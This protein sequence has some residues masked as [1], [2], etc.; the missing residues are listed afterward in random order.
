M[1]VLI[2]FHGGGWRQ[3]DKSDIEKPN[4]AYIRDAM[5][6]RG[7]AVISA[8][9]R[10]IGPPLT[11]SA[12]AED[13]KDVIRWVYKNAVLYD[14]DTD[15]IGLWGTSSGAHLAMLMAYSAD[16]DFLGADELQP[17]SSVANYV[18]DTFG[19]AD[20]NALYQTNIPDNSIPTDELRLT[21]KALVKAFTGMDTETDMTGITELCK[22]YSPVTYITNTSVPTLIFH[23]NNDTTVPYTQSQNLDNKLTSLGVEH[24]FHTYTYAEPGHGFDRFTRDQIVDMGG[25][26][27]DFILDHLR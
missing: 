8:N 14:F 23:S 15:N 25:K 18:I 9:H 16:S 6:A 17:Y 10:F 3:Q 4:Q 7:F 26:M 24:E 22:K 1:P 19:P 11:I 5:L 2:Y 20:I 13:C 12:P 27:I 21:R